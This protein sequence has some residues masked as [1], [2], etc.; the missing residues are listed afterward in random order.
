MLL[1][2]R[3][4]GALGLPRATLRF[5]TPADFL[6]GREVIGSETALAADF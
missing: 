2:S 4:R 1:F 5:F 6:L 3:D